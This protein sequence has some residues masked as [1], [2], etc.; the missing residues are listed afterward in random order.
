MEKI[1]L[2]CLL[3]MTNLVGGV[4][5]MC[6]LSKESM[7]TSGNYNSFNLAL[8]ACRTRIDTITRSFGD[9]Q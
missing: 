1:S 9:R 5:K 4:D 8:L 2:A 7:N 3:E 6:G